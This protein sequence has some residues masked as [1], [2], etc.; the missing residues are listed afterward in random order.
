LHLHEAWFYLGVSRVKVL[1]AESD[2]KTAA[3]IRTALQMCGCEII[4]AG[5]ARR[6]LSAAQQNKFDLFLVDLSLPRPSDMD[7]EEVIRKLKDMHQDANIITIASD[8]TRELEQQVRRHGI[9]C[10]LTKPVL[11]SLIRELVSHLCCRTTHSARHTR[12]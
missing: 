11:P 6:C 9:L 12:A 3:E 5:T 10:Y 7:C 8:N 2:R 1:L 4:S